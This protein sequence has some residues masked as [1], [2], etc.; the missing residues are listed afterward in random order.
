MLKY[1]PLVT[2]AG[3]LSLA[4]SAYATNPPTKTLTLFNNSSETIYPVIE[5]PI[6]NADRWMQA[7]FQSK[8]AFA[9]THVRRAYLNPNTGGMPPGSTATVTVP[10]YSTL[11]S[12]PDNGNINNQYVDWW[13]GIRVYLYDDAQA[14]A[15][16][17]RS[18][19]EHP[20]KVYANQLSCS[21][22][23]ACSGNL[24]VFEADVGLP[25]ND[26][27]QLTEYTF[28]NLI[29]HPSGAATLDT[30][31]VDYDLSYVDQVYLPVALEPAGNPQVGYTGTI[32]DLSKFR[33]IL[34]QFVTSYQWPIYTQTP[35]YPFP[36]IPGT[37][38]VLIGNQSLT[39]PEASN[40]SQ[41]LIN[42]WNACLDTPSHANHKACLYVNDLF[43]ANYRHYQ[44]ICADSSALTTV[45]LLQNIYGWVPF[46][47][48]DQNNSLVDTPDLPAGETYTL[49]E[50][51]YHT[52]QYSGEFNPYV[53][54][55]HSQSQLNMSAYA[56]SIDDAIGNMNQP[57]TGIV[58]A[59]GGGQGLPN[60]QPYPKS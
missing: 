56:Y 16:V 8:A 41:V 36:R 15:R 5:S 25:L 57:G 50:T 51:A 28:A 54:L 32:M 58:I 1:G 26:P 7:L 4:I 18:D 19:A 55:I 34:S 2:S 13:N 45:H 40:L 20:L 44:K 31:Y 10:F 52:L 48:A 9:T 43:Q 47:C 24:A 29:G 33:G 6:S 22:G 37:Y 42:N 59:I 27:Y 60:Q 11:S 46:N 38:N 39:E 14:L 17:Y 23:S 3:L 30:H 21:S 49:A 12:H 35:L 53:Q